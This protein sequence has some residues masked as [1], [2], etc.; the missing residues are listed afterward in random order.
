MADEASQPLLDRGAESFRQDP[1]SARETSPSHATHQARPFELSTE[2]TP[3]LIRRDNDGQLTYGT[4][5]TPR[6]SSHAEACISDRLSKKSRSRLQWPFVFA[7]AS[8]VVVLAVL[9]FAFAAPATVRRYAEEAAVFKPT[10]LSIDSSTAN[11]VRAR[12][13]G[14]FAVD[15]NRAQRGTVRNLG[16]LATWIGREAETSQ[17]D[18]EVYLPEYGNILVG[19][20]SIPS[21]KVNIR[22]GHTNHVDF[23]AN[24][25]AGDIPGIRAVAMDWLEQRL[26]RLRVNGKSTL[27][28]KSGI[29]NLG[30]QK[31]ARSITFEGG[32][33]L[34]P[35]LPLSRVTDSTCRGRFPCPASRQS[36]K[37][38]CP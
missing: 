2:S 18:L 24:L 11:G 10:H 36:Q 29:F 1:L 33:S 16:R 12:V 19:T 20:A 37:V 6:R 26:G 5:S 34:Q 13:Q 23:M 35:L 7:L 14:D 30:M 17:S 4:D 38:D 9:V 25:A 32:F 21:I 27:K 28:I 22:D 8:L 3:L 15:A 31:V